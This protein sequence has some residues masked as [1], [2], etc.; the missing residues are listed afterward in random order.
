L[1][2]GK[3]TSKKGKNMFFIYQSDGSIISRLPGG[4]GILTPAKSTE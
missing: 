3:F 1:A 2:H 4:K